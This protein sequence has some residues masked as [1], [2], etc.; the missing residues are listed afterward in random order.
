MRPTRRG[1][2]GQ[3]TVELALVLPL[4]AILVLLVLQAG[5]V[6]R[7]QLLAAHAAREAVRA[8]SVS[9]GDRAAAA[10]RAAARAGGPI[11]ARQ[12]LFG[13]I[14]REAVRLMSVR[15]ALELMLEQM[16]GPNNAS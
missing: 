5:L 12:R 13:D 2:G 11:L 6:I 14:G 10:A 8:A 9:D 4:V 16:N 15:A 7:D 1:D 3:A